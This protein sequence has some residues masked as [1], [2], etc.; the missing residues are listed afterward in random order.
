MNHKKNFV[1]IRLKLISVVILSIIMLLEVEF[2]V[3]YVFFKDA[4]SERSF[5]YY[6]LKTGP[7][8]AI[9]IVIIIALI[10][11]FLK[12][13]LI[14]PINSLTEVTSNFAY[15]T[16]DNRRD[17]VNR[18]FALK[19]H[20]RKDELGRLYSAIAMTS[21][22]SM[23]FADDIMR[24]AETITRMQSGLLMVIAEMV[25]S[26]DHVTGNHIKK[27]KA[28]V[29]LIVNEMKKN[30][31]FK[32]KLTE[33]YAY[34]IINAAPLHDV[35]K[36][37]IPDRILL[38]TGKLSDEDYEVMKTHTTH[39]A[40]MIQYAIDTM[41]GEDT[42]YLEEAKNVAQYHHEKWNGQGYPMG[43]KGEEIPLSARIMAV[44]DVFDAIYSKRSYKEPVPFE[45]TIRIIR[46]G[47]GVYFD[48]LIVDVFL[49]AEE[50]VKKIADGFDEKG[51]N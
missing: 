6:L 10:M 19:Y 44:A 9:V 26:R 42:G 3:N 17:N 31:I 38:G 20:K 5:L 21:R 34:N 29:E 18:I 48:P 49:G 2:A 35:G 28:Y 4:F 50:E 51:A 36:I 46:E 12:K 8:I 33:K 11:L 37:H 23:E 25:E 1:S 39:G 16:N 24:Q 30:E 7:I 15:D 40:R 45:E 13:D 41:G 14:D 32:D 43:I 27:T 47:S 22:E